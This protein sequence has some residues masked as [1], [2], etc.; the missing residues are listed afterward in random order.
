M[1]HTS[2]ALT[3]LDWHS[4]SNEDIQH[5]DDKGYLIIRNVLDSETVDK[6][7]EASD[8]LIASDLREKRQTYPN[9]LYD[10][11]RNCVATDDAF[12]PLLAHKTMLSVVTQLLGAHLQL[13]VSHLIYKYPDPPG[14]PDTARVPGWHRDYGTATKVLGDKVPRVLL[15]CAYY[16][17]D[18]SESNSGATLVVP[19]S[20]N[21]PDPIPV[22]EGQMDPK[23]AFEPSLRPGDC[24]LFENRIL[25]AGGANL[26]DQI[27]KAVMFGYGY[28]WLMPLDY[29][30][31]EQT[32]L[33]KLSPLGQYLV[34]EPFKKTKEY[35]AGGGDSPLAAWCKEHGVPA[36]RPIH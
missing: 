30:T 10:G 18:L 12:I 3:D 11:F 32:L 6:L 17:T 27:R 36:I 23:G 24:L 16:L 1:A 13:V 20:N 2:E 22:P 19:G 7:I 14:T 29:R 4:L 5:F 31:Q 25:H 21:L 35:Y 28:R 15:K 33:D 26:T 34:G 8:R 9:G